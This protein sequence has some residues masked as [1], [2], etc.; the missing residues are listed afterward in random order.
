MHVPHAVAGPGVLTGPGGAPLR[1]AA[2]ARAAVA[3]EYR[4][5]IP[6][7]SHFREIS[8]QFVPV[9]TFA[10]KW[11]QLH[12]GSELIEGLNH[13][14]LRK[15]VDQLATN[16]NLKLFVATVGKPLHLHENTNRKL[17]MDVVK[18]VHVGKSHHSYFQKC[19]YLHFSTNVGV[20]ES[21]RE[22]M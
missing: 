17:L 10:D 9:A 8:Q 5:L 2:N 12:S 15:P 16:A 20:R 19:V 14:L 11:S 18:W 7:L 4:S 1:L 6:F 13:K 3:Q 22:T 21:E